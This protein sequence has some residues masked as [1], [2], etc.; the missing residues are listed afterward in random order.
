LSLAGLP[1]TPKSISI[2]G[3]SQLL[4]DIQCENLCQYLDVIRGKHERL[5][6]V[7]EY[8]GT[9]I[10]EKHSADIDV[11][12]IV[13]ILYQT[14]KALDHLWQR[15]IVHHNLEPSNILLD[16][17]NNVK[18]FNY[19]LFYMTNSGHYIAFPV[20]KSVKYLAPERILGADGSIKSD[21]WSLAV[22]IVELLFGQPLWQSLKLSQVM[23]KILSFVNTKNVLEKIA[24][25]HGCP[26]KYQSL[27]PALRELLEA[28]LSISAKDRPTPE[29]IL[30][31][32]LF[33]SPERYAAKSRPKPARLMDRLDLK[34][35]YYLY[36]LAGGDVEVEL[37]R[38]GLVRNEAPILSVPK[39]VL[40][41][42]QTVGE[43]K[44]QSGLFDDRVVF[45]SFNNLTERLAALP[46][47]AYYPL[48]H[49]PKLTVNYGGQMQKL[50]LVIRER[51]TEYQFYRVV[52]FE[53]LLKA[54]PSTRDLIVK[55][56]AID[57]P[58]LLRGRIW[59]CILWVLEDSGN[60]E[61]IDKV[62]PTPTDRQID[63]DIPRCHQYNELLASPTGHAKLKRLL[64]SWVT[65][66]PQYV[67][68]KFEAA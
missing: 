32:P 67:S 42:G 13:T 60:Y 10:N 68:V 41:N 52:L 12:V 4:K 49:A 27:T 56:A 57:I 40:L 30:K 47:R 7:S 18:L 25:E 54:Y 23:R 45:L 9:P 15:G 43:T 48:L 16:D 33:G 51:D 61:R 21:V 28:C 46:K 19:G 1:L 29:A 26:E 36:L 58:P 55:E 2:L 66:H 6:V 35:L 11:D 3:R 50:P 34:I 65:S 14:A 5:I 38:Q 20:G 22:I 17:W 8:Y 63:V 53:R 24:N 31:H 64:K 59:A 62:T 44:T 39:L 37:K